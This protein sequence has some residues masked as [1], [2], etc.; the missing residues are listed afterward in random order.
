MFTEKLPNRL[1]HSVI[2]V[3]ISCHQV[4]EDW[5][6]VLWWVKTWTIVSTGWRH[7]FQLSSYLNSLTPKDVTVILIYRKTPSISR[8]L[9]QK[10]NWKIF[11]VI[12]QS[13]GAT[14][15]RVFFIGVVPAWVVETSQIYMS[16]VN[17]YVATTRMAPM[18]WLGECEN[19]N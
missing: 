7:L 4:P 15:T 3:V 17:S 12:S 1:Q 8:D 19:N 9:Y 16:A 18:P 11:Q 10:L 5:P 14:Y 13:W 2:V 6:S